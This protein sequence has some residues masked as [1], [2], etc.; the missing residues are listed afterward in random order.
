MRNNR[1]LVYAIL[2]VLALSSV[3]ATLHSKGTI[4]GYVFLD[5]N[6]NGLLDAGEEGIPGVFVTISYGDYQHTYYTGAGDPNGDPPGPGSYGPSPL[7]PGYWKVTVHVPDGYRAT[8]RTELFANVPEGGAA[9]GIDFGLAGSG[10]ITYASG[11]GTGMGGGGG[12]GMGMR[13]MGRGTYSYQPT[14]PIQSNPATNEQEIDI[15]SKH[16]EELER[17]LREVKKRLEELK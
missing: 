4:R 7:Q 13:G 2:A 14:M 6:G 5:A 16:M 10:P 17:Q 3:G 1:W 12:R 11:T 15:L 9:T 8:S